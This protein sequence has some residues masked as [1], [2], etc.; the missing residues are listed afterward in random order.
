[1]HCNTYTARKS[2]WNFTRAT[3][4]AVEDVQVFSVS[5]KFQGMC[6]EL[7]LVCIVFLVLVLTWFV[8]SRE[9]GSVRVSL[10]T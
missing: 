8:K 3:P 10:K 7:N 2:V 1:M 5:I 6:W 9:L 4:V